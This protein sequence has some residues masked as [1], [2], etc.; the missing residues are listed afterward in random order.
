MRSAFAPV[1]S[2]RD[3]FEREVMGAGDARPAGDAIFGEGDAAA[4]L[5]DRLSQEL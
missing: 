4:V 3:L 2:H 5:H 1:P